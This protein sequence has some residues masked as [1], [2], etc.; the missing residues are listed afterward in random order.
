MADEENMLKNINLYGGIVFSQK[1]LLKIRTDLY[2]KLLNL[3]IDFYNKVKTGDLM[4]RMT[5]G[6]DAIRHFVAWVIY[7]IISTTTTFAFAI[8]SMMYVNS[9]LTIFMLLVAPIIGF[10][11]FKLLF[12]SLIFL[13]IRSNALP[14]AAAVSHEQPHKKQLSG[15]P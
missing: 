7:N 4:A 3:D 9:I 11:T 5:G 14:A 8:I 6:T 10:L 2:D 12:A 15:G 13:L 1:V